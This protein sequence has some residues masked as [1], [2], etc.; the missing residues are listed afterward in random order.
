MITQS[1]S[2][3]LE[4][5]EV[6]KHQSDLSVFSGATGETGLTGGTRESVSPK[7]THSKEEEIY[8]IPSY[9][10]NKKGSNHRPG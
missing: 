5:I 2:P 4:E 9:V 6:N 1:K 8:K 3:E 10:S 7:K